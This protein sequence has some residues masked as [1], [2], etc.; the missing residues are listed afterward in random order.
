MGRRHNIKY[1]MTKA[2]SRAELSGIRTIHGTEWHSPYICTKPKW[3]QRNK[4]WWLIKCAHDIFVQTL[5]Y[6]STHFTVIKDSKKCWILLR[7]QLFLLW[8]YVTMFIIWQEA[9]P[10]ITSQQ[11]YSD[12]WDDWQR[13]RITALHHGV[14]CVTYMQACTQ[15]CNGANVLGQH[16]LHSRLEI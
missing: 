1:V 10:T 2:E 7:K 4:K 8:Y 5:S 6:H 15:H 12:K 3:L 13:V 11:S 16:Q 14:R 9:A